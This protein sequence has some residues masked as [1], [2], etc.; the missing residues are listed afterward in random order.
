MKTVLTGGKFNRIHTG[1]VWLLKKAKS[2]GYLIVVLAHDRHNNRAYAAPAAKRKKTLEA[3]G[4]ADKVVVGSSSGFVGIVKKLKPDLV[5]LGYDQKMPD[6]AT[7]E[8]VRKNKI[9]IIRLKR[10][11]TH[12]TR[13]M[14]D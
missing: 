5:V 12:S 14:K 8:Y 2:L 3:L 7:G 10:H 1:H 4:I 11:G 9:K 13:K 6:N